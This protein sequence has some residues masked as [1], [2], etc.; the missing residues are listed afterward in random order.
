MAR[1]FPADSV[2]WL[3]RRDKSGA[4]TPPVRYVLFDQDVFQFQRKLHPASRI[5]RAPQSRDAQLRNVLGTLQ[6]LQSQLELYKL[7]HVDRMPDFARFSDWEQLLQP[8][9]GDG[10]I[11]EHGE[12]GPYLDLPP[13]NALTGFTRVILTTGGRK[14]AQQLVDEK[15]GYVIDP[16]LGKVWAVDVQG[17]CLAT[18]RRDS[19]AR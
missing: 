18:P 16:K 12:F 4:P 19:R 11:E 1:N 5:P 13:E 9:G 8:T 14:T 10:T 17:N 3:R 2:M 15:V 6:A 7:Q